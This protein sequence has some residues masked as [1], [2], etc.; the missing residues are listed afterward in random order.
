M[1]GKFRVRATFTRPDGT[2]VESPFCRSFGCISEALIW[3]AGLRA[4]LP[5]DD[6]TITDPNGYAVPPD[7]TG[8]FYPQLLTRNPDLAHPRVSR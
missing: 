6:V 1:F 3:K 5:L 2:V 4:V 7:H 8:C